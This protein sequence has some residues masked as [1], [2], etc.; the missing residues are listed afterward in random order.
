MGAARAPHL[1]TPGGLATEPGLESKTLRWAF[2]IFILFRTL[3]E[4]LK[5]SL[6]SIHPVIKPSR[7]T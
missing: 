6:S 7:F 3:F 2:I 5:S 4:I 1:S